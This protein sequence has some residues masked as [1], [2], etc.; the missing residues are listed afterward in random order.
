MPA[1]EPSVSIII[2]TRNEAENIAALV[3]RIV[4]AAVPFH[5]IVFVD[6]HSTDGSPDIIRSLAT[7]HPIRLI[8]QNSALPG[9]AAAIVSGASVASGELLLMMDA[10]LSHPPERINDLLA[11]LR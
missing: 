3:S 7:I 10:D 9:L 6:D 1:P 4:E 8:D 2:P 11:P 5:E